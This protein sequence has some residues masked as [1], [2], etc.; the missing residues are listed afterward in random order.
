MTEADV[1]F[2]LVDPL[3]ELT[4][5]LVRRHLVRGNLVVA[6]TAQAPAFMNH[7]RFFFYLF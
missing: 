3:I 1:L 5:K 7:R 6:A 4:L 2:M